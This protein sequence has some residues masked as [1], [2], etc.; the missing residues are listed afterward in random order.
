VAVL[1]LW[2]CRCTALQKPLSFN[3]VTRLRSMVVIP[4]VA[5]SCTFGEGITA[6]KQN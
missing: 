2:I 5:W 6:K 3:G 1:L 4:P